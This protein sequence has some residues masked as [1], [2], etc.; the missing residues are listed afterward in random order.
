MV[1]EGENYFSHEKEVFNSFA[2]TIDSLLDNGNDVIADATHINKASRM[3]LLNTLDLANV[4][5]IPVV[6]KPS[7]EIAL[8]RNSKRE[9]RA[10]VPENVI[11]RMYSQWED[12]TV[13]E[14]LYA[15]ILT[16]NA[17]EDFE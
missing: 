4:A 12:P 8:K 6:V 5:V 14:Y 15:V 13:D 7:L 10:N 1:K 17:E 2:H 3:K 16:V 9:G 11:R